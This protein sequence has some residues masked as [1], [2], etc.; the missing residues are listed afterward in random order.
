LEAKFICLD[1][2]AFYALIEK[3]VARIK[4]EKDIK[5][6]L[7]LSGEEAMKKLK[8]K[9]KTTLAKIVANCEIVHTYASPRVIMYETASINECLKNKSIKPF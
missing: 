5:E 2:P 6:P 8:I 7:W 3:V 4:D 9:S 1:E